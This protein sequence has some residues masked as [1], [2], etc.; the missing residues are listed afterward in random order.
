MTKLEEYGPTI[1]ITH[2]MVNIIKLIKNAK[3]NIPEERLRFLLTHIVT[4]YIVRKN[5]NIAQIF[6]NE[7][8]YC[9]N[10]QSIL[11]NEYLDLKKVRILPHNWNQLWTGKELNFEHIDLRI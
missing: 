4:Q 2:K 7:L 10:A 9:M 8:K 6:L 11:L 3:Y 1:D 5:K